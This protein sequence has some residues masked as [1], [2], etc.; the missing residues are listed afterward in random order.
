MPC[1]D[2]CRADGIDCPDINPSPGYRTGAPWPALI[3]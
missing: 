3:E 2:A 1:F